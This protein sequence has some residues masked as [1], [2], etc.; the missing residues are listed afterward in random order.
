MRVCECVCVRRDDG[1]ESFLEVFVLFR[2]LMESEMAVYFSSL[3]LTM[4]YGRMN[5]ELMGRFRVG[6]CRSRY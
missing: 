1:Y 4:F 3:A 6:V 2:S 5:Y